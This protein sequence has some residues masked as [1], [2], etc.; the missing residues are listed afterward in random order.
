MATINLSSAATSLSQYTQPQISADLAARSAWNG[1]PPSAPT[2]TGGI[3]VVP[4]IRVAVAVPSRALGLSAAHSYMDDF[5]YRVYLTPSSLDLG[6]ITTA[7]QRSIEVWNAWPDQA[8]TLNN[9]QAANAE[10][11]AVTAP[12]GYPITFLPLQSRTWQVSVTPNGPGIVNATLSWLFAD[13]SHDVTLAITGNRLTAWTILPDWSN[14]ITETLA[15][16]TDVGESVNGSQARTPLRGDPR[17]QWEAGYIAY[18]TDRQLAESLL[19]GAAA[20]NYVVPVWWDGDVLTATLGAGAASIPLPTAGRDYAVGA[21]VLLWGSATNY[22]LV[23]VAGTAA[24]AVTLANPTVNIWPA[25]TRVWPCRTAALTDTPQITRKNDRLI[26]STIRFEARE[27]CDWTAIAPATIYAGYPVL[28]QRPNEADDLSAQYARKLVTLDNQIALPDV[29]DFSGLAWPTQ[30]HAWL[31]QGRPDQSAHRSLLYWLA[32]RAQPVWIPSWQDDVTL[33]GPVASNATTLNVAWAGIA[34]Y[35]TL[36]PGRRRLRIEL[37][38]GT[39]LYRA[40]TAAAEVG[41]QSESLA[42]D[43]ALGV[44]IDPAAVRAISWMMLATLAGDSVEIHHVTD[45]DGITQCVVSF[46]GVPMEEP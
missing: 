13:A 29:D 1:W 44:A 12:G 33:T 40:V 10:G 21:Q 34:R 7:Q 42:L 8:L 11:I 23:E 32:G 26:E 17:R 6:Q 20:R 2:D 37:T 41:Q 22:E 36:S 9:V 46:A 24:N 5:Y 43:S 25:G 45:G 38:D 14:G 28:E 4:L 35:L 27:P 16:L 31:L 18:G 19:Y 15:W 30:S 39:V 3:G